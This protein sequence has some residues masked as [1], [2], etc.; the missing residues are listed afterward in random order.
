MKT[1]IGSGVKNRGKNSFS[2]G[3]N[4]VT[5]MIAELG[6]IDNPIIEKAKYAGVEVFECYTKKPKGQLVMRR[7][8]DDW[9][10]ITQIFKLAKFSKAKRTRIL[11]TE[12]KNI[13]HE[14]IQGGYGRFQGT[15]IALEDAK[16]IIEKYQL[17]NPVA[18]KLV[19]F[20]E[21]PNN[22]IPLREK[23]HALKKQ[24]KLNAL[25]ASN[26]YDKI[27]TS[28]SSL[29]SSS[30][31]KKN[32]ASSINGVNEEV[33]GVP[34]S[35]SL[36]TPL[37]FQQH[38]ANS[39][40]GNFGT[41][42]NNKKRSIAQDQLQP[43]N[44]NDDTESDRTITMECTTEER[45]TVASPYKRT[46]SN[47][48]SPSKDKDNL[49]TQNGKFSKNSM[50]QQN[51]VNG[52]NGTTKPLQ[53][54]PYPTSNMKRFHQTP[55]INKKTLSRN[56]STSTKKW[57]ETPH[58]ITHSELKA[59]NQSHILDSN[60]MNPSI[61]S[62]LMTYQ[63]RVTNITRNPDGGITSTPFVHPI[64]TADY[65]HLL[66]KFLSSSNSAASQEEIVFPKELYFPP[67]DFNPNFI[68][69]GEG[70]S[71]LH[72]AVS[73]GN[74]PLVQFLLT[75]LKA[76]P[77]VC[78]A[79]GF[80]CITKACFYNNCYKN[81]VFVD[82]L[83]CLAQCLISPDKN[84][85]LPLH[86]LMELSVNMAK[87]QEVI[88]YYLDCVLQVVSIPFPQSEISANGIHSTHTDLADPLKTNINNEGRNGKRKRHPS[89][90]LDEKDHVGNGLDK[91][92][93]SHMMLNLLPTV[94]NY[95]DELGNTPLHV[96]ALNMNFDLCSKLIAMGGS[97]DLLN[98]E[99]CSVSDILHKAQ[100]LLSSETTGPH[101]APQPRFPKSSMQ[102]GTEFY[103]N[104]NHH[105]KDLG[106][107]PKI[108]F[109][110][111]N[112]NEYQ[113]PQLNNVT[114]SDFANEKFPIVYPSNGSNHKNDKLSFSNKVATKNVYELKNKV[115]NSKVSALEKHEIGATGGTQDNI[116]SG[117]NIVPSLS[118]VD[119]QL[120]GK[121]H[122]HNELSEALESGDFSA[123][124]THVISPDPNG[125]LM[126]NDSSNLQSLQRYPHHEMS[127]ISKE[128]AQEDKQLLPP[129]TPSK[130]NGMGSAN[131]AL[132]SGGNM[133]VQSNAM[134][135]KVHKLNN[136]V[137]NF[138]NQLDEVY[139]RRQ[140]NKLTFRRNLEEAEQK[141]QVYKDHARAF[142]KHRS[143]I[144]EQEKR[145][146][147]K[148]KELE[149]FKLKYFNSIEK[150]QGLRFA[151]AFVNMGDHLP[152]KALDEPT[153]KEFEQKQKRITYSIKIS[154]AQLKRNKKIAKICSTKA[155]SNNEKIFKYRK[156]IGKSVK[157]IDSKLDGIEK[158][159]R[160]T[161]E[162]STVSFSLPQPKE[163]G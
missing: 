70:N 124:G 38:L 71:T 29:S 13:R 45:S 149:R 132:Y 128:E 44:E 56:A 91:S 63:S 18:T 47:S 42:S 84:G 112:V 123:Y 156:L 102:N 67:P 59:A 26:G 138:T 52:T 125:N 48:Q 74:L 98:Y 19:S 10:N 120:L 147:A 94:L 116:L 73:M 12:S 118:S 163:S 142:E 34:K 17:Q 114:T 60:T 155:L 97:Q 82:M 93:N 136:M 95:Q 90:S 39:A 15:W 64:S 160:K 69:D 65:Q 113:N 66:L 25:E 140:E 161:E 6:T 139:F 50:S 36:E 72:W 126:G 157:N 121:S 31:D 105:S 79:K 40:E 23:L 85:R 108:E 89:P 101:S 5:G 16:Y 62:P 27:I 80:N 46:K 154:L 61:N 11:E 33:N 153:T 32:P 53:F 78:N 30:Y 129:S 68:L 107:H 119:E 86:Y 106:Q 117:S 1:P 141:L 133:S 87:E 152:E 92:H 122:H 51:G 110:E 58:G 21:D 77:L 158:D 134:F 28:S 35:S 99:N 143:E 37:K 150:S 109:P 151:T 100:F 43:H 131:S 103:L 83:L 55:V 159:L 111:F 49:H 8:R 20:V 104:K 127:F 2:V 57:M 75:N 135:T 130:P 146:L 76:D 137:I 81:Q 54:F 145:L 22:P 88:S 41:N 3:K 148:Q 7:V 24:M 144:A 115:P 96:A 162:I 4:G 9:I 14:K